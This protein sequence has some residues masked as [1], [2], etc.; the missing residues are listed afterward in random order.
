MKEIV[1]GEDKTNPLTDDEIVARLSASTRAPIA[2]RTI[3]KYRA[4]LGIPSNR[5]RKAY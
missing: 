5:E 2:R 1:D 3:A 4:Q